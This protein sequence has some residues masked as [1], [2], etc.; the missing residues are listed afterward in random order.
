MQHQN[1]ICQSLEDEKW[2]PVVVELL[3]DLCL[4][5]PGTLHDLYLSTDKNS[6]PWT[7]AR[8]VLHQVFGRL[9]S[10]LETDM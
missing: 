1:H 10:D 6:Q 4:P 8:F 3:T 7:G 2:A 5:M 9:Q